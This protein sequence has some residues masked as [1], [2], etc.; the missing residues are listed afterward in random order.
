[1]INPTPDSLDYTKSPDGLIPA[2]VQDATTRQ[3]L[4]QGYMNADALMKTYDSGLVTF[5][6]RSRQQLWTKGET[7]GNTLHFVSAR[8]DCD[9]DSLLILARPTGPVCHT[10]AATCYG[11]RDTVGFMY[12]LERTVQQRRD[13][14]DP[15]SSYTAKLL[16]RGI[17]KVAQKVGEEAVEVV[18]EAKDDNRDLFINEA[19]DLLYHLTVLLAAKD[20]TLSEVE[21]VLQ[22]RHKYTVT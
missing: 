6:S 9:R 14:G 12:A 1:M 3:V 19:A 7:S 22:E 17:N 5:Y 10:G 8:T 21:A 11:E 2:I 20:V 18:I 16:S 13:E 15:D 4:M